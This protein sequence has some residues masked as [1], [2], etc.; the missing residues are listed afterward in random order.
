VLTRLVAEAGIPFVNTPTWCGATSVIYSITGVACAP[1]VLVPLGLLGATMVSDSRENLLQFAANA[2]HLAAKAQI[3]RLPASLVAL[4]T[5][6]GAIVV[7]GAVMLLC[8]YHGNGMQALDGDGN[9]RHEVR[10]ITGPIITGIDG[11]DPIAPHTW[12]CYGIGA[13]ITGALGVA[14]LAWSWWPLHP[15]GY[16]ASATYASVMTWFSLFLG[17]LIKLLVLRYGGMRAYQQLKPVAFGMIA[18]EAVL[19]GGFLLIRLFC[20]LCDIQLPGKPPQFLPP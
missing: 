4:V 7:S 3:R 13:A 11:G 14:R 20:G 9:W 10:K 16:L 17:W 2:D 19:V 1:A 6:A 18:G 15:L 12:L 8:A 5:V